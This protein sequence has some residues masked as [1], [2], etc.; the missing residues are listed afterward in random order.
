ME[1]P[2]ERKSRQLALQLNAE[3]AAVLLVH[4]GDLSPAAGC[5]VLTSQETGL[6]HLA[7]VGE[8]SPDR[9]PQTPVQLLGGQKK[10]KF[11]WLYG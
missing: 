5:H 8:E 3:A 10:K 6:D 9:C 2:V 11:S 4:Q 1:V 7:Q